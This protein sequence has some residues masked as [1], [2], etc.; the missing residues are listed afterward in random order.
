MDNMLTSGFIGRKL[1]LVIRGTSHSPQLDFTFS[2]LPSGLVFDKDEL[3]RFMKRRAP[4]RDKFSSARREADKVEFVSGESGGVVTEK[5]IRGII[6][7]TDIR[8]RDYEPMKRV[9]RPGHADYAQYVRFGR[10]L[11][12]GGNNSGRLT[13][14][15]CAA[16]GICL[17]F[18]EKRGI[19]IKAKLKECGGNAR[20]P[21]AEI[22]MAKSEG[23]SV[24]G[25]I[26]CEIKG[27]PPG[28]G[29][30]LFGGL[31][32]AISAAVFAIPG[33]KGIEFGSG[34]AAARMRGSENND[35]FLM[36]NGKVVTLTNNHGGILGGYSSGMPIVFRVAMKP[37]PSI[38][39]RQ[40]SVDLVTMKR[41]V[42]EIGG[43]HDPCIAH[44]AVPAVEAVAALA[45]ADA[46]LAEKK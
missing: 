5:K 18:L 37:T 24:G 15:L 25:L 38:A 20:N 42:L 29:G 7:N 46:I 11:P 30:A 19:T 22:L 45:L 39:K 28:I 44:R 14:A 43:R 3:A 9:P 41:A 21:Q 2:G 1:R 36:K 13:A 27:M 40:A 23:D 12:G 17:Q 10:I 34:F 6:A 31:D 32:G 35:P 16:G 26:A 33:V 8:P 4:G